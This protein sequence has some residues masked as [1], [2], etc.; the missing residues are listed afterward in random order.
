MKAKVLGRVMKKK[1]TNV[2][3]GNQEWHIENLPLDYNLD[4]PS[5]RN[6]LLGAEIFPY[7]SGRIFGKRRQPAA[8]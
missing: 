8:L 4:I 3:V 2:L 5:P 1:K 7:I 6:M